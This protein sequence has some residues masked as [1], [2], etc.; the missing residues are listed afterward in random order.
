[1]HGVCVNMVFFVHVS[2]LKDNSLLKSPGNPHLH[3]LA[4]LRIPPVSRAN[5][6][7]RTVALVIDHCSVHHIRVVVCHC[8]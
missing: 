5:L 6:L 1:M 3:Y 4:L 7:M 8:L 2:L